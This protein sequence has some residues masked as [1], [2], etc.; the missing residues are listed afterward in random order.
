MEKNKWI[1]WTCLICG[2]CFESLEHEFDDETS[3][4]LYSHKKEYIEKND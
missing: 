2:N 4:H 1:K 3:N